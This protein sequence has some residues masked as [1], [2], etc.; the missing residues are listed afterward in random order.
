[1]KKTITPEIKQKIFTLY[2]GQEIVI[3][4]HFTKPQEPMCVFQYWYDE[5][6]E[7]V[8]VGDES[9]LHLKS[10]QSITDEDAIECGFMQCDDESSANYG[11]SASGCFVDALSSPNFYGIL[12]LHAID[13]LRSRGYA[14]PYMDWSVDELIESGVFKLKEDK[15]IN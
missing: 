10:L 8:T 4:P 9:C 12:D 15:K 14:L 2:W 5:I 1:M 3:M 6:F 7:S 11:M 13:Y